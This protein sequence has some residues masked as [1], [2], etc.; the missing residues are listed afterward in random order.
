M[1]ARTALAGAA[2]FGLAS[3]AAAQG[4]A[5]STA[6][7]DLI[8]PAIRH[9]DHL[10]FIAS[11]WRHR[12]VQCHAVDGSAGA[13]ADAD[14]AAIVA[15]GVPPLVKPGR[16]LN[17]SDWFRSDDLKTIRSGDYSIELLLEVGLD[18]HVAGCVPYHRSGVPALDEMTCRA[19]TSRARFKP[20]TLDGAPT[21]AVGT[22]VVHL[23]VPA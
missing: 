7:A 3:L 14:C 20:A 6:D 12:I 5:A 18:G 1:T 16:P 23:A 21:R 15:Q 10:Y 4:V 8:Y 19:V 11:D 13:A 17:K 22:V 2:L 9:G